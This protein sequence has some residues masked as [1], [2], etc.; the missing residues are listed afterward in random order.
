MPVRRERFFAPEGLAKR[1]GRRLNVLLFNTEAQRRGG[2]ENSIQKLSV[3]L[4]D[5]ASFR[6]CVSVPPCLC[7]SSRDVDFGRLAAAG[8]AF[9]DG[10][11]DVGDL[12]G[13]FEGDV[14]ALL[15]FEAVDGH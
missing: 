15:A 10:G 1:A 4:S 11:A 7:V 12:A 2:A 8:G 9:A 3:C 6:L 13:I 14:E 5:F